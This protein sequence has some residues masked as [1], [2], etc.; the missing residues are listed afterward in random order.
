MNILEEVTMFQTTVSG[1]LP[2]V[3]LLLATAA[4]RADEPPAPSQE[5]VKAAVGKAL[6]PLLKGAEGHVAA[7]TC[8]AC[9]NQ[10]IPLLAFTTAR[11]RGFSVRDEDLKKQLEHI[12]AFLKR[13]RES[14]RQG[15]SH[16]GQPD[17]AGYALFALELGGWKPDATTEAVVEYLLLHD[18]DLGHWRAAGDRPPSSGSDFTATALALRA[19]RKW[20]VPGQKERIARRQGAGRRWLLEAPAR[21]TEGRVF[22]LWALRGEGA[23]QKEVRS[24]RRDLIRSQR[25]DGG[26]GQTETMDSDAYATGTALVALHQAGGLPTTDRAYRRGVAFLLKAQ[27]KNGTW[28]VRSRSKPLQRYYE[29][30]FP[31]GKDQFISITASAW[32]TTALAL[33]CPRPVKGEAFK[34]E[35]Q[36]LKGTWRLISR[37]VDGK[38][39]REEEFTGVTLTH[40]EAGKISARRGGK[41]IAEGTVRLDPTKRPRMID[42]T[43]TAGP[44]KGKTVLGI[45]ESEGGTLRLCHARPGDDRPTA[46]STRPTSGQ[47]LIVYQRERE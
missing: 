1:V 18:K 2:V 13:Y 42:I 26:W 21:D 38:K 17:T 8:F 19:L 32:A 37:E 3:V 4:G 36:A 44:N 35:L 12:A 23:D 14:Y 10:A 5:L 9:H 20:G 41:V 29:S 15:K 6:P 45:Y 31:H 33:T 43:F 11:E 24:A 39:V 28:R 7:K 47:V 40:D 25:A 16:P 30:G 27:Q 46:F 22:R 34:K